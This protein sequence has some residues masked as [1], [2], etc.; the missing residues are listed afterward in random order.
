LNFID[1]F[2]PEYGMAARIVKRY[3]VTSFT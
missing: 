1:F 2:K 3:W